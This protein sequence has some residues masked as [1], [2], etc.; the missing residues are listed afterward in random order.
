MSRIGARVSSALRF[1]VPFAN[2]N[3]SKRAKT[4]RRARLAVAVVMCFMAAAV[5]DSLVGSALALA[6]PS[7]SLFTPTEGT[8]GT[9][10]AIVGGALKRAVAP[11]VFLSGSGPTTVAL[12]PTP[13][14][15]EAAASSL[16]R[17]DAI[18]CLAG[19]AP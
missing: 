6:N 1:N 5:S 18:V 4:T 8:V 16:D 2:G 12:F 17:D 3:R 15:A 7:I 14:E 13:S 10:V 19:S 11:A 9:Q